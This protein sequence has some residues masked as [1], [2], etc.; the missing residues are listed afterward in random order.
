MK[1]VSSIKLQL[2]NCQHPMQNVMC[3]I[4]IDLSVTSGEQKFALLYNIEQTTFCTIAPR[5][6]FVQY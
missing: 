5:P 2:F 6:P 3:D 1:K 4:C